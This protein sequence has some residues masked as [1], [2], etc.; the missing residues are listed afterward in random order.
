MQRRYGIKLIGHPP[1]F[2]K[3]T[4]T[5]VGKTP[6]IFLNIL[7]IVDGFLVARN[8]ELASFISYKYFTEVSIAVIKVIAQI[9]LLFRIN[10]V[11][12]LGQ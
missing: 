7:E 3:G 12:Q 4:P 1:W 9:N 11:E 8:G 2:G 6:K 10:Y 5:S